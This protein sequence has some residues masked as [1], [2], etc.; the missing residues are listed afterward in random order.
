MP[1]NDYVID[2]DL[3][4]EMQRLDIQGRLFTS[5]MGGLLPERPD[6]ADIKRVLD[7]ACGSGEWALEVAATHPNIEVVGVDKAPRM[8]EFAHARAS[9][10]RL[11]NARFRVM[12]ITEPLPFPDKSFDLLNARLLQGFMATTTW[13]PLL[14]ECQRIVRPGGLMR[15][16]E[17]ERH[18]T[19]SPAWEEMMTLMMRAMR[20]AG[21]GFSPDGLHLGM[22]FMQRRLLEE[23][24]FVQIQER[25]YTINFSYGTEAHDH[26]CQEMTTAMRLG[27]PFI[28]RMLPD[29]TQEHLEQ[30]LQRV[31]QEVAEPSFCGLW[32]FLSSSGQKPQEP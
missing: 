27:Q 15:I 13:A 14:Q 7:L 26:V 3:M 23:A 22:F 31:I 20:I 1:D 12:D 29:Y 11:T 10:D 25:A 16:T 24:G 6:F 2:P 5:A 21:K 18:L 28:L 17:N 8:I 4:E 19:S 9:A 30:L 32:L